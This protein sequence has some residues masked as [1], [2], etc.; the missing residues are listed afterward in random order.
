MAKQVRWTSEAETTFEGVIE[1]L[2]SKWTDREIEKFVSATNRVVDY[3]SEQ[4][5]MFRKTNKRNV[6]EALLTTHNLLI[7]KVYPTHIDLITFWDTR[8]NPRKKK[9]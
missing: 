1:Y 7:Y 4:P 3:I 9:F 2:E 5:K 6:H 8:R